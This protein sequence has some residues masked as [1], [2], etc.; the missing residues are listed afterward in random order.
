MKS[1]FLL[2]LLMICTSLLFAQQDLSNPTQTYAHAR[3][4]PKGKVPQRV[5][6]L[7]ILGDTVHYLNASK[8]PVQKPLDEIRQIKASTG[9]RVLPFA[10]IGAGIGSFNRKWANIYPS[11]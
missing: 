1:I 6:K 3:I 7:Q 4:Y 11:Q 9:A 5:W 10:G 2:C 8:R